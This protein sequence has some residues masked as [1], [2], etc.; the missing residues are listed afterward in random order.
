[1]AGGR[2]WDKVDRLRW[3]RVR[4]VVLER[5]GWRCRAGRLEVDHVEPIGDGGFVYDLEALQTLCRSCHIRKTAGEN[6]DRQKTLTPQQAAWRA[7]TGGGPAVII[8]QICRISAA[9]RGILTKYRPI[10]ESETASKRPSAW[11]AAALNIPLI[12]QRITTT[13]LKIG[14]GW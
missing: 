12:N 13:S 2:A 14:T 4:R 9:V 11:L 3:K 7:G 1:M 10:V 6:R 8:Q 5:D